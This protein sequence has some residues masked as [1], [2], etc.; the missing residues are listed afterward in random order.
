MIKRV[1]A[2]AVVLRS[3]AKFVALTQ[4]FILYV[5]LSNVGMSDLCKC[6]CHICWYV[7]QM[8]I[9]HFCML[10]VICWFFSYVCWLSEVDFS[11]PY[12][13]WSDVHLSD[14]YVDLSDVDPSDIHLS[15]LYVDWSDVGPSDLYVD[16]SN[17]NFFRSLCWLVRYPFVSYVCWLVS[18][19][20]VNSLDV[21]GS[22]GG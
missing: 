10:T 13:D 5:D 19:W 22:F 3:N 14:L 8:F 11:V 2:T 7:C 18:C 21:D 4:T 12:V 16:M 17:V 15:D 9:C 1:F 20:S 6:I